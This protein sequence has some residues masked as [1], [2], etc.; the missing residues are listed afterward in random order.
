MTASN[1]P[2]GVRNS[3]PGNIRWGDPWQGLVPIDQRLDPDFCQ[4]VDPAWGIRALARTLI[5][6]QDKHGLRTVRG[7][8]SRW[9]PDSENNTDAYVH[10]VCLQTGLDKREPLNMHRYDHLRP[11]LEAIIRHECGKGPMRTANTWYANDVIEVALQR[12]G[13]VREAAAVAAVPVTK[14]TIGATTTGLVGMAQ[15]GE[16][17]PSVIAAVEKA[18]SHISSGSMVRIGFGL[19]LIAVSVYIAWSQVRKYRDG[20]VA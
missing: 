15:I 2:R 7:I 3:N 11:L 20:V 18:D 12:A 9:A 16:V 5:T 17:M 13:V 10:A 19:L 6:Y 14:E 4:F 1:L 8:I